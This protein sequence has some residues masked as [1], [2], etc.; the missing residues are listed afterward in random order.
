MFAL[1]TEHVSS[2]MFAT[3]QKAILETPAIFINVLEN[4]QMIQ[5]SAHLTEDALD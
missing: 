1:G 2:Q 3:V 4:S 5:M